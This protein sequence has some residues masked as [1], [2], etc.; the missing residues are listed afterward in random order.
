MLTDLN[1]KLRKASDEYF[2]IGLTEFQKTRDKNWY[3]SQAALGNLSISIELMLKSCIAN[4]TPRY[5]FS[6]L[7]LEIEL[8]LLYPDV[9]QK[10]SFHQKRDIL[11]F[12]YNSQTLASCI[13]IYYLMYP[14]EKKKLKPYLSFLNNIR[15]QSVHSALL[16]FQRIELERIA[17]LAIYL[18]EFLKE[19]KVFP[20]YSFF[21]SKNDKIFFSE[22][23]EKRIDR[24]RKMIDS[25]KE[26]A[27][28]ITIQTAIY[29]D[30]DWETRL[31]ECPICKCDGILGGYTE[32]YYDGP[33]Y[34]MSAF[35]NFTG[36][37]FHCD[38]CKLELFDQAELS[39]AGV[40]SDFDISDEIQQY[41]QDNEYVDEEHDMYEM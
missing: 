28:K 40:E 7:P 4:R 27:K 24:V 16:N 14:N 35:L 10:L 6:N 12:N 31:A 38:E 32:I 17:Y 13:S 34:D 21:T 18:S 26:N 1:I 23:D 11:N 36:E 2:K 15:N 9:F 22:Y 25:A 33:D 39:F 29:I 20:K 37:S 30:E 5:V 3:F 41:I 19:K 8:K